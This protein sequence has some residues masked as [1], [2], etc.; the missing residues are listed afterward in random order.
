[1]QP[2]A[3]TPLG[4]ALAAIIAILITALA[5][6]AAEHPL[7]ARG[8]RATIRQLE[9]LVRR[10]DAL[11]AEWQATRHRPRPTRAGPITRG[12][13]YAPIHSAFVSNPRRAI[14]ARNPAIAPR[15]PPSSPSR[16]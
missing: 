9:D 5:E 7:L 4:Q 6:H 14:A 13:S 10:F 11:A 15:A 12:P 16:A 8:C 2:V 3:T 1:M